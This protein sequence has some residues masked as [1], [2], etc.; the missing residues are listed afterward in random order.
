M[1]LTHER[2]PLGGKKR[3]ITQEIALHKF[4]WTLGKPK[5]QLLRASS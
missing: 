3:K 1:K 4:E 2:M 5:F